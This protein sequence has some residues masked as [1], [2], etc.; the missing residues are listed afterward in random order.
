MSGRTFSGRFHPRSNNWDV[1][2]PGAFLFAPYPIPYL[3]HPRFTPGTCLLLGGPTKRA[4]ETGANVAEPK[5]FNAVDTRPGHLTHHFFCSE[6]LLGQ[7]IIPANASDQLRMRKR[8]H[9]EDWVDLPEDYRSAG[10]DRIH[11]LSLRQG[12]GANLI[13]S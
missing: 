13:A 1:G 5:S 12:E 7:S 11:P 2:G 9:S 4:L 6:H 3:L 10:L 8:A